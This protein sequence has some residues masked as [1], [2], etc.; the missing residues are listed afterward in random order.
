VTNQNKTLPIPVTPFTQVIVCKKNSC[1]ISDLTLNSNQSINKLITELYID[2][3][4]L[5]QTQDLCMS[6]KKAF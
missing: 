1:N 5:Q 4:A 6:R 3:L 2:A